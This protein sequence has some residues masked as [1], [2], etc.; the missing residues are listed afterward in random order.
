MKRKSLAGERGKKL[1]KKRRR[2]IYSKAAAITRAAIVS[3][4]QIST[5]E[6]QKLGKQRKNH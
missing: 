5:L 4:V 6:L 2:R 3:V 1:K